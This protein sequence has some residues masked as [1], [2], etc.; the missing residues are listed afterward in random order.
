MAQL[1]GGASSLLR[2]GMGQVRREATPLVLELHESLP[3][4]IRLVMQVVA[5]PVSC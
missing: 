2:P 4:T 3:L 5:H 1:S